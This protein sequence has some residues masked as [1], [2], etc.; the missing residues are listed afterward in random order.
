M[1]K[2]LA[3]K[4]PIVAYK[5][6]AKEID[7][8]LM[9]YLEAG[10]DLIQMARALGRK[11]PWAA[12]FMKHPVVLSRLQVLNALHE[13]SQT[14]KMVAGIGEIK[15]KLTKTMRGE[16]HASEIAE[17]FE[18]AKKNPTVEVASKGE[19]LALARDPVDLRLKVAA[20]RTRNEATQTSAAM[21]LA[22]IQGA[23]ES[24]QKPDLTREAL[25]NLIV[26]N[27]LRAG[28]RPSRILEK[29]KAAEPID[30]TVDHVSEP[31]EPESPGETAAG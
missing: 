3:Q 11:T 21:A 18:D 29:M 28:V 25:A 16:H 26:S 24:N 4:E 19:I 13:N 9:V 2:A 14:A 31:G 12:I 10:G 23:L 27:F 6:T 7:A 17:I 22:R 5:M 8:A 20:Q 30:V 15:L 1:T